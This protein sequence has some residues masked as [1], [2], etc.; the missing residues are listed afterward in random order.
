MAVPLPL[1]TPVIVVVK[2]MAGVL[3]AV[4][5]VPAKP[6]AETTETL[7]TVPLVAGAAQV[8]APPVVAV[9]TWPVVPF[10]KDV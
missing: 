9:N 5:T 10:A 6:L 2:V 4:A 1:R 8:G 7:V 3:V